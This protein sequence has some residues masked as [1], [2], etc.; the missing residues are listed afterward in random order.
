MNCTLLWK[1]VWLSRPYCLST[2]NNHWRITT[3]LQVFLALVPGRHYARRL[4]ANSS[5]YNMPPTLIYFHFLTDCEWVDN[6]EKPDAKVDEFEQWKKQQMLLANKL[7]P[8]DEVP[9]IKQGEVHYL[10]ISLSSNTI[11]IKQMLV[12]FHDFQG[13]FFQGFLLPDLNNTK[14]SVLD[15]VLKLVED[16][17]RRE[18]LHVS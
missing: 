17:N 14:N 4:L 6:S 16:W 12:F 7:T 10:L 1:Q 15:W 11:N 18:M 2:S 8:L 5:Y 13:H 3:K 9:P